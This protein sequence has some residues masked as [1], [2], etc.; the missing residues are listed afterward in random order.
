MNT[1]HAKSFQREIYKNK[2]KNNNNKKSPWEKEK[3]V[4]TVS[5]SSLFTGPHIK[6]SNKKKHLKSI[7]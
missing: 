4:S 2:L 7:I 6:N 3:Y 5:I 1:E